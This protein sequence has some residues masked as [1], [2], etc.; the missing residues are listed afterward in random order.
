M[1]L[2]KKRALQ[3]PLVAAMAMLLAIFVSSC[4]GVNKVPIHQNIAKAEAAID[5]A[6]RIEARAHAPL[7]LELAQEKLSRAK[8]AFV[9][10]EYEQADWLAEEALVEANLA[11]AKARSAKTQMTVDEL[12]ATIQ[13]LQEEIQRQQK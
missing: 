7:E 10:E 2:K 12:Q 9:D 5:E 6:E 8:A 1:N 3:A 4:G 11:E 13:T